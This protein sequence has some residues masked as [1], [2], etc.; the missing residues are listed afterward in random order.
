MERTERHDDH[1]AEFDANHAGCRC[2]E[3]PRF[4]IVVEGFITPLRLFRDLLL[5][6]QSRQRSDLLIGALESFVSVA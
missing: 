2:F 1:D 5:H 3:D 6:N 4:A